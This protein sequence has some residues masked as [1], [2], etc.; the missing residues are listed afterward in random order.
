[1]SI[2]LMLYKSGS[3]VPPDSVIQGGMSILLMLYKSDSGVPPDSAIQ[4]GWG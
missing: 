3:G 2:L 1:M 4:G